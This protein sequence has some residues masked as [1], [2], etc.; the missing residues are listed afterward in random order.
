MNNTYSADQAATDLWN[1]Y[2]EDPTEDQAEDQAE[3]QV[4]GLADIDLYLV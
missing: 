2:L 1:E 3:D 4:E